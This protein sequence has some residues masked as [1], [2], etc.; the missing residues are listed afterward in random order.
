M[1]AVTSPGE[2]DRRTWELS[3][4]WEMRAALRSGELTVEGSRRYTAWDTGLYYQQSWGDRRGAWFAERGLPA[5]GTAFLA[6]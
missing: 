4:V 1:K 6:S 5:D 2:V 3:L